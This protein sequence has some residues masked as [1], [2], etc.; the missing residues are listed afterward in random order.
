MTSITSRVLFLCTG[1]YYRSRFAEH[2]FN[3]LV[4]D[5][6][7]PWQAFSRGLAIEMVDEHAG[8]ISPFTLQGLAA[9][10]I[11][12]GAPARGPIALSEQDLAAAHHI[13]ALKQAEHR[14][15]LSRTF[16]DWVERVEYWHVHDIDVALPEDALPQIEEAV[17]GLLNRLAIGIHPLNVLSL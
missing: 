4:P 7:L 10:G 15:L 17:Q 13:V 6:G 2:L 12:F 3:H 9:R 5:Y 1:N 14:P 16:P 8:P 11:P